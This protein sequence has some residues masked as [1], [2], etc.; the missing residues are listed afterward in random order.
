MMQNKVE[1]MSRLGKSFN[2]TRKLFSADMIFPYPPF[3]ESPMHYL[4]MPES[5]GRKIKVIMT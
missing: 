1:F 3:L 2:S 4:L 5:L